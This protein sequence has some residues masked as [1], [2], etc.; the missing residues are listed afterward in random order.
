MNLWDALG[1]VSDAHKA[2][3]A[4]CE[5]DNGMDSVA[6]EIEESSIKDAASA[7][8]KL[9]G[10]KGGAARAASLSP[11]RRS[12]IARRAAKKRWEGRNEL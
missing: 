11:E 1:L 9:G 7:L 2:V 6:N 12:E 8:G 10:M 4:K 3:S 5:Y